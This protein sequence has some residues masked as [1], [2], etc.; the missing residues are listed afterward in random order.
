MVERRLRLRGAAAFGAGLAVGLLVTLAPPRMQERRRRLAAPPPRCL[1]RERQ[2][3]RAAEFVERERAHAALF[4]P[5]SPWTA[6]GVGS[7]LLQH[8]EAPRPTTR[9]H[10]R[11]LNGTRR[12]T[13]E[14]YPA[15][16]AEVDAAIVGGARSPG[17]CLLLAETNSKALPYHV[18][19][20][21]RT[22]ERWA[23]Q[24]RGDRRAPLPGAAARARARRRRLAFD[25]GFDAMSRELKV[26]LARVALPARGTAASR[27]ARRGLGRV[28]L[29]VADSRTVHLVLNFVAS[30]RRLDADAG[31]LV[32]AADAA[33]QRILQRARVPTFRH[34]ALGDVAGGDYG[35]YGDRAFVDA[36]WLKTAAVYA[37]SVLG[38]DVLF[39][40]ADVVW[41][42][43]DVWDA[44]YA[45]A[46]DS[47]WMDDGVRT[48]RFAPFFANSGFYLLRATWRSELLLAHLLNSYSVVVARQSHQAVLNPALAEANAMAGLSVSILDPDV[49]VNGGARNKVRADLRSG[50]RR[51]AVFHVN[52]TGGTAEKRGALR[53]L[54]LWFLREGCDV[55]ED[56]AACLP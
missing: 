18:L 23:L 33:A 1:P 21:K 7:V 49:V 43:P 24:R 35:A 27:F 3:W 12:L 26:A 15:H 20:Y 32:I 17:R 22:A 31:L 14:E 52:F 39:Q 50:A 4:G 51:V 28:L 40:D 55:A 41:L 48:D 11:L 36:M 9:Y 19:T 38:Y 2:T 45:P 8:K 44:V 47:A 25:R 42:R 56:A 53:G 13:D 5:R 37:A 54:G 16:C 6:P 29:T 46:T 30:A 34:A 10:R